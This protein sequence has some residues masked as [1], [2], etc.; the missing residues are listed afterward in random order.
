MV[1]RGIFVHGIFWSGV[2]MEEWILSWEVKGWKF[3]ACG[4]CR[5][6]GIVSGYGEDP[7]PEECRSCNG[8]GTVWRT[9]KGRYVEYPGGRFV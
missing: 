9:P 6:Y 2:M 5:G 4:V 1:T 8:R 7:G 3:E